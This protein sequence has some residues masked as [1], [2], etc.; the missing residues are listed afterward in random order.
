M[1]TLIKSQLADALLYM[2]LF[3][4]LEEKLPDKPDWGD[5]MH[6]VL[7]DVIPLKSDWRS[8]DTVYAWLVA[9]DFNGYDLTTENPN[10]PKE[11]AA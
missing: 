3:A 9:N 4:G 2:E 8:D 11:P 10:P 7:P 1:T 5:G 6:L